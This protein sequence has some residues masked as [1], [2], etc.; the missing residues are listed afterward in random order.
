MFSHSSTSSSAMIDTQ[1]EHL[2]VFKNVLVEIWKR[3]RSLPS[4]ATRP[5]LACELTHGAVVRHE[6]GIPRTQEC[7]V[8]VDATA[9]NKGDHA[10]IT[11]ARLPIV[12]INECLR[13]DGAGLSSELF[14]FWEP[15]LAHL[16]RV[17][18]CQTN[19]R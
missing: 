15:R 10:A 1:R 12:L 3:G 16:R 17:Y 4:R 13:A 6:H 18:E 8:Q 7:G 19:P 9:V 5:W 2:G 14:P 11:S